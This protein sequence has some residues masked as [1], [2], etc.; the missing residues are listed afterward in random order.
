MN[1][2][3]VFTRARSLYRRGS[4][5]AHMT[6]IQRDEYY[7]RSGRNGSYN[8]DGFNK[9]KSDAFIML[10]AFGLE[11]QSK[12]ARFLQHYTPPHRMISRARMAHPASSGFYNVHPRLKTVSWYSPVPT[13][14]LPR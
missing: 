6:P 10:S 13:P 3:E 12:A 7:T 9:D 14:N 4:N 8:P 11:M 5:P 2:R 1:A